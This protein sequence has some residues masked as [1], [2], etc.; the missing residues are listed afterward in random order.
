MSS[1]LLVFGG[2]TEARE[3]LESGIPALCSVATEYGAKMMEGVSTARTIVG[4]MDTEEMAA[5][6]KAEQI[7]AVID[8]THPYA[9]VVTANIKQACEITGTPLLRLLRDKTDYR[10]NVDVVMTCDEAASLLNGTDERAL[11]TVG[12]KE[13]RCFTSVKNYQ[14]RLYARVLPSSEVIAGCEKLG[15]DAGHII[16]MQG[17]FTKEMNEQMLIMTGASVI[18]T[19]DGG[20]SG[21]MEE[22][23][24]AAKSA[25]ARIILIVRPDERGSS[26]NEALRWAKDRLGFNV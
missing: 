22:K 13:L 4:R 25:G 20:K 8:A 6:I 10:S 1:G 18:V 16:A 19:K 26:V 9:R 24:E 14:Q 17:P 11:L 23:L 15:F 12:S 21:G 3:L 7:S 5:L 2:T